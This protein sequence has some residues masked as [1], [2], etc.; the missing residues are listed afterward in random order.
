MIEIDGDFLI[1]IIY[2]APIQRGSYAIY[3][4][5]Q[6]IARYLLDKVT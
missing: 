2:K 5:C 6:E 1:S 3:R 4:D